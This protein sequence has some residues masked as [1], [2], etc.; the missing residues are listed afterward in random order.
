MEISMPDNEEIIMEI[1][2]PDIYGK[3]KGYY[4]SGYFR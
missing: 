4:H 3:N 2:M 1:N